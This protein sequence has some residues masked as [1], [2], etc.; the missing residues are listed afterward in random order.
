MLV[1]GLSLFA[2]RNAQLAEISVGASQDVRCQSGGEGRVGELCPGAA[3]RLAA[4]LAELSG[5]RAALTR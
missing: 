1:E 2:A 5:H 3:A 4:A